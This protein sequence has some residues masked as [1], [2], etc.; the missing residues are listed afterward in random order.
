MSGVEQTEGEPVA[1]RPRNENS[2]AVALSQKVT[3]LIGHSSDEASGIKKH[4]I[5]FFNNYVFS[6]TFLCT[7]NT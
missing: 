5:Y 6:T 4:I 2:E 1:K 3:P 7:G